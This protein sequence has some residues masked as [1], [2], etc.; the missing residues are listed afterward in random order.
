MYT[1]THL[2]SPLS[3][4]AMTPLSLSRIRAMALLIVIMMLA[5]ASSNTASGGA[6]YPS[7]RRQ[8]QG[9]LDEP[10]VGSSQPGNTDNAGTDTTSA[11]SDLQLGQPAPIIAPLPIPAAMMNTTPSSSPPLP[12][13][14]PYLANAVDATGANTITPAAGS[15]NNNAG[16]IVTPVSPALA[17][18]G[19][20]PTATL[21]NTNPII[22][23]TYRIT[24]GS[25]PPP[26]RT[27]SSS[28]PAQVVPVPQSPV[29][30]APRGF[31]VCALVGTW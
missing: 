21:I 4:A 23:R 13:L 20:T 14:E 3:D 19:T 29:L 30:N 9:T 12:P 1:A 24:V 22:A 18:A 17:A 7:P 25:L 10:A 16:A 5:I 15:S 6:V 11:P 26:F 28:K 31:Q 8:S 2:T 27:Q